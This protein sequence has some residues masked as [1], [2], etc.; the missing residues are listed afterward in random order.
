MMTRVVAS[1]SL[2]RRNVLKTVHARNPLIE[3]HRIP[4]PTITNGFQ[5]SLAVTCLTNVVVIEWGV[6]A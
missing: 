6:V 3:Q 4:A 2:M 1:R 5:A